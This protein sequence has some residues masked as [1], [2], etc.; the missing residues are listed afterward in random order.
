MIVPRSLLR[1]A[2]SE[3][4]TYRHNMFD[5]IKFKLQ[6]DSLPQQLM[7]EPLLLSRLLSEVRI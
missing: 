5:E 1:Q 6:F 7:Y 2:C 3:P 4:V